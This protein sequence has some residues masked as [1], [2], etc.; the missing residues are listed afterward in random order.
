MKVHLD[1]G[2][3]HTKCGLIWG[4]YDAE[5]G[6]E[7]IEFNAVDDKEFVTCKSCLSKRGGRGESFL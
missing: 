2:D 4:W 6:V 3:G 1:V 7:E 5:E